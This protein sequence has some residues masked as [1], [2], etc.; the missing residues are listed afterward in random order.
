MPLALPVHVVDHNRSCTPNGRLV[1]ERKV[2]ELSS[3]RGEYASACYRPKP[4]ETRNQVICPKGLA[5][6][7]LAKPLAPAALGLDQRVLL[8]LIGFGRPLLLGFAEVVVQ[9][10]DRLQVEELRRERL[11]GLEE[12]IDSPLNLRIVATK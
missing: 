1:D 4:L 9:P 6:I 2:C 3:S 8:G 5:R 12:L 7:T 11:R 10:V